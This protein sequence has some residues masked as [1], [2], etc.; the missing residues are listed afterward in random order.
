M[1]PRLKRRRAFSADVLWIALHFAFVASL[2]AVYVRREPWVLGCALPGYLER[3]NGDCTVALLADDRGLFLWDVRK[4]RRLRD[5]RGAGTDYGE[6]RWLTIKERFVLHDW[7]SHT[8]KCSLRVCSLQTGE[9]FDVLGGR[10]FTATTLSPDGQRLLVIDKLSYEARLL[11]ARTGDKKAALP[12]MKVRCAVF[13]PDQGRVFVTGAY[14]PWVGLWDPARPSLLWK[15]RVAGASPF[16]VATSPDGRRA[17]VGVMDNGAFSVVDL[18]EGKV[19]YELDLRG[20]PSARSE[21]QLPASGVFSSDGQR[22]LALRVDGFLCLF[23][24]VNGKLLFR[25]KASNS[26]RCYSR[27][28]DRRRFA[29]LVDD[30]RDYT[31]RGIV[32]ADIKTGETLAR[33][34]LPSYDEL[35]GDLYVGSLEWSFADHCLIA[36]NMLFR[37]RHPERWWGHFYRPEVWAA[38][39]SGAVWFWSVATWLWRNRRRMRREWR[40]ALCLD[41][42][43]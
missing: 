36:G 34:R 32:V 25:T 4:G 7:D 33:I 16:Y 37:R 22:I 31:P 28:V 10:R 40:R 17:L 42:G 6:A 18:R 30:D 19:A 27:S 8:G 2:A 20:R 1:S 3:L 21:E 39:V 14:G 29:L 43:T 11:D 41:P 26:P 15:T 12:S 35:G 24:A 9:G 13:L 5:V 38:A 23:D